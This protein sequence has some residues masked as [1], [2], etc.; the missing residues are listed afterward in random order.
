MAHSIAP[1]EALSEWQDFCRQAKQAE[2]NP[3]RVRLFPAASLTVDLSGQRYSTALE[4]AANQLL[5]V[6]ELR[7]WQTQLLNGEPI[8]TTE[9]RAAWHTMLRAPAPIAEVV[10]ERERMNAF[11][12][13]ADA[14]RRWRHI[15]H[16]GIGGSDWGVR[17][18]VNAFGYTK[19][20]RNVR[21]VANIDGHAIASGTANLN[22]HDTLIVIASKSFSTAET[23]LNAQR[24]IEWLQSAGVTDPYSQIVAVTA[25]TEA[26]HAFGIPNT[27]IF[28]LWD[29]VGGRFSVWSA[30]SLTTALAVNSDVVAGMHAGAAAMDQHFEEAPW[31][32]NAP[33]QMA[34]AGLINRSVLGYGSLN[35]APYDSR[36]SDLVPYL[37]QLEMESLGKSVD[38]EGNPITVPTG[39]AVWGM[40]GTDAQ[41]TFFQ[42]LHQGSDGA[43]V[44]FIVCQGADHQW[45]E[46]HQCLLANCL[47]Q[48]EAMLVGKNYEQALNECLRQ[49]HDPDTAS[50]LAKHRVHQGGRPNTLIVL[51]RL[52]PYTLG[53]LLALYEHKIAVQARI[54]GINPFDQWGVEYGK[55]LA[56][57]IIDEFKNPAQNSH[58]RRTPD[59]S[60]QHWIE[61]FKRTMG[62]GS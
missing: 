18:T 56:S 44:D 61:T 42:W 37:Q 32:N 50:W 31:E 39:P 30:V 22:P 24:A 41:H 19:L 16:I 25:N 52:S 43:P 8:N 62:K 46:H 28:K 51:P 49:G 29:W 21:F 34:L 40:P 5:Q 38:L 13:H 55:N 7:Q 59:A 20:W 9:N 6:R 11:I 15:V 2:V 27:Q 17:L 14:T 4:T 47:A 58:Q 45:L 36:L 53:A 10:K 3:K 57:G 35:I 26:A 12:R 48:R 33:I 60:T 54:W 23:L 1:L